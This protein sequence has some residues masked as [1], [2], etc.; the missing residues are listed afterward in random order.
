[1]L[2]FI[3]YWEVKDN[4][5]IKFDDPQYIT[6][7]TNVQNG[8]NFASIHWAFSTLHIDAFY[9]HPIT[10]LSHMLDCQLFG[11]DARWHH[12]T[13]L[14]IH[15]FNSLLL[16]FF[17]RQTTGR[18]W[19]SAFVAA[20]FALHPLHV[21]SV[22]WA[23]ERKD[24]LS[25]LFWISASIAYT[26]YVR[27]PTFGRYLTVL[28]LF[29]LG[30]MSKP[31]TVTLPFVWLLLDYWPLER[32]FHSPFGKGHT[33][34]HR[35]HIQSQTGYTLLIEKL[36]FFILSFIVS[37]ITWIAQHQ[38][39]ALK[40]IDT[41]PISIRLANGISAYVSYIGKMLFPYD[42]AIVYPFTL[43]T[44]S[45]AKTALSGFLLLGISFLV[46]RYSRKYKYLSVGWFWYLGTLVPVIGL[47]QV[48]WQSSADR[49]TYIPLIGLF[50]IIAWGVPDLIAGWKNRSYVLAS[51]AGITILLLCI[52]TR[53]QV[54]YWRNT[55]TLFTHAAKVT[56]D[57][58]V[59]YTVLASICGDTQKSYALLR[60]ALAIR[61]DYYYA[62]CHLGIIYSVWNKWDKAIFHLKQA[63]RLQ[64]DYFFAHHSLAEVYC[65][66]KK[67][68]KAL[69]HFTEA[70]HYRLEWESP[71]NDIISLLLNHR[72]DT[73]KDLDNTIEV[74]E[75][76]NADGLKR[77][78]MI[79]ALSVAYFAA[80]QYSNAILEAE[81]AQQLAAEIDRHQLAASIQNYLEILQNEQTDPMDPRGR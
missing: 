61:P 68:S 7:N 22:A 17:F 45:Y 38:V 32:A 9:W 60:R 2:T 8:I 57:N 35:R 43:S 66:Q 15:I 54:R 78:R 65:T 55:E 74:L 53:T 21:E 3:A 40:S 62:H 1:M 36:P 76:V 44:I 64:P 75:A 71:V 14:I 46:L 67:Y 47:T 80:G 39:G 30:L 6:L 79:F 58:Y 70:L 28:L 29:V 4:D 63:L 26:Y 69:H 24:L 11:L 33:A 73:F 19:S 31:M 5:F 72:G 10:W 13:G 34:A 27:R 37:V 77:P 42:L 25:A 41:F 49:F 16:F 56:R 50:I 59:A 20:L 12:I 52:Y 51:L 23:A 48:G 81:K 18:I